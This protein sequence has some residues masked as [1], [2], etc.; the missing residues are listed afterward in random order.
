MAKGDIIRL[1]SRFS[2]RRI[3]ADIAVRALGEGAAVG[4]K[5]PSSPKNKVRTS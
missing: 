1:R 4:R 3:A 2:I 5:R